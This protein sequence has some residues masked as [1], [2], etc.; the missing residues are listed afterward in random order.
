[1]KHYFYIDPK[2]AHHDINPNEFVLYS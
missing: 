2:L 1:M